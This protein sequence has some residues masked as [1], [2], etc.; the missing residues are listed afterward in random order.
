[1][2]TIFYVFA[3]A[4]TFSGCQSNAGTSPPSEFSKT[5][6]QQDG[7]QKGAKTISSAEVKTL[8]EKKKDLVILDVRTPEEFSRG[9]LKNAILIDK[10]ATDFEASIKALD[11]NKPYLLYCAKGGRS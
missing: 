10:Y 8:I 1:M 4:I 7:T 5:E 3:T 9:H 11:R 2:R 6:Q